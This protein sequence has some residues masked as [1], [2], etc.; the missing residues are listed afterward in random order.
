MNPRK[1]FDSFGDEARKKYEALM[2]SGEHKKW[3]LFEKFK[4]KLFV[5]ETVSV[6]SNFFI[7]QNKFIDNQFVLY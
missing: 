3:Y 4:M 1:Q 6:H 2:K 5:K 7:P